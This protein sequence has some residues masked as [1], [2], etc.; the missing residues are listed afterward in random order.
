MKIALITD[1]WH[2]QINGVVRTWSIVVDELTRAGHEIVT[3]T[4]GDFRGLPCPGEPQIRLALATPAAIGERLKAMAPE[5]IHIATEGPLGTAAR[6]YC[7]RQG[8]A[9]TTSYH[10]HFPQYLKM[11]MGVPRRLTY[12]VIRRFHQAATRVMVTTPTLAAELASHGI[13]HTVLWPRGVD[14]RVFAPR[15][16]AVTI[17]GPGPVMIYVGRVAVEKNIA[18]FLNVDRPGTK[19]VVGDGPARERLEAEYPDVIF[20][21]WQTGAALARWYAAADIFV[22]PSRTDTYGLVLLEALASGLPVAAYPV[23]GPQDVLGDA[24]HVA[25]LDNDLGQAID[26]ALKL[27]PEAARVHALSFSWAAC[28]QRFADQ[29]EPLAPS[30]WQE[31]RAGSLLARAAAPA[32]RLLVG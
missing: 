14:A 2:P 29:V 24:P 12:G 3:I 11:R 26:G 15:D 25:C 21:G 30:V 22:F 7:S 27:S 1:A 18:A 23:P 6:A 10:T 8:L 5:A 17:D 9:F 4:P 16:D 32:R 13:T 20:A 19:I 28:A 31:A